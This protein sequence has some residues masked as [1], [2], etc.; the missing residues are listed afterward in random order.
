ML[1]RDE[2]ERY[3]ER[4]NDRS[5]SPTAYAIAHGAW[6]S[7][8]YKDENG[9]GYGWWWLRSPGSSAEDAAYVTDDGGI[10]SDLVSNT[11]GAVRPAM[12]IDL[13]LFK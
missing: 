1:S 2:A 11:D 3:F 12:W 13:A 4:A 8:S 5:S 6:I 7:D 10:Y 9:S